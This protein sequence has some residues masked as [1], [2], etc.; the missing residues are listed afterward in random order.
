MV[1]DHSC[2]TNV[3]IETPK[4]TYPDTHEAAQF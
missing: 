3:R 1:Y 2:L 4:Q